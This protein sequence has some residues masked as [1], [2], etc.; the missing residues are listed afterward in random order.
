MMIGLKSVRNGPK[1]A[2]IF[3]LFRFLVLQFYHGIEKKK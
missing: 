3:V 1:S 2:F